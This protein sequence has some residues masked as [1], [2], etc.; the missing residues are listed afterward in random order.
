MTIR[1]N[2]ASG[3]PLYLQLIEQLKLA[4]ETGA[5][6]A[7]EQL[8]SIREMAEE[9]VINPNTVVR[10]YRDLETE[11]IIELR[12]GAGAF[13]CV[14]V[15][16]RAKLMNKAQA[17]VQSAID[18]LAALDLTEDEIRRLVENELAGRRSR[19]PVRKKYA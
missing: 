10:A 2:P 16:P 1:V 19:K 3:V 13:V 9:L 11:G 7:G 18:Q 5:I 17:V 6:R 12:H 14:S 4:L 8:P 15:V